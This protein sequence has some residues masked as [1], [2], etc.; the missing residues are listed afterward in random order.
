MEDARAGGAL[1]IVAS[2]NDGR[3]PVSFPAS[4]SMA[5]AVSATGRVGTFPKDSTASGD[6]M[7]PYGKDKKNFIAAF[8]NVG[9]E[10]DVTGAGVDILSTVPGGY[11]PLSGTSMAC[12]A[13]TGVAARLLAEHANILSMARDQTGSDAIARLLLQS[14]KPLGF[15]ARFEGQGM[16]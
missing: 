2:G 8:S 12:P 3:K 1:V 13:V 7:A 5:I 10:I 4:D 15:A 14:A 6:I 9:P 16:L 11:A